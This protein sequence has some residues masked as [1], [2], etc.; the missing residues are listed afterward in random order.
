MLHVT[1][2]P[3][4][5]LRVYAH[6][7]PDSRE[8]ARHAIGTVFSVP[9]RKS[10]AHL[11]P[12]EVPTAPDLDFCAGHGPFPWPDPLKFLK[13]A[14]AGVAAGH[15]RVTQRARRPRGP[16]RGTSREAEGG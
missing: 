4:L 2:H 7:M 10:T 6:L 9:L 3:A 14:L 1:H 15:P 12:G 16:L 11:R 8:H 13:C 5:T